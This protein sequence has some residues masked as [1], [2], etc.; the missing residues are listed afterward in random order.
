MDKILKLLEIA[1]KFGVKP[2]KVIGTQGNIV[3]YKKPSLVDISVDEFKLKESIDKGTLTMDKVQQEM[4]ETVKLALSKNLNDVELN[5]A[6]NNAINIDR[7]FFP[8]MA[9]VVE[10]G[11]KQQVTGKGLEEL[12]QKEG[13][14]AS[15]KTPLGQ[16]QLRG[17]RLEQEAKDLS[18]EFDIGTLIKGAGRDQLSEIRLHNEGLVRAVT[19]Q[20]LSEDIKAGKIKSLTLDDLGTSR[21]PIDYFRK[22][23]GENA[24]EQLDSLTA[25][26]NRLN[27]EQEAASLARS[28]FKFEPDETRTKGSMSYEELEKTIKGSEQPKETKVLDITTEGNKRKSIDEL[29]DEYNA[30]QDRLR[31]SD[32]EGGTAINYDEFNDLKKKN[33]DI[34]KVLEEKGI[35]SKI[36]EEIKEEGIVIP[37]RKKFP[38]PE[39]EGKAQGGIIG[40]AIG[41]RIGYA[42]GTSMAGLVFNP[43]PWEGPWTGPEILG[44]PRKGQYYNESGSS[45]TSLNVPRS[46]LYKMTTANIMPGTGGFP[47]GPLSSPTTT[48]D[49]IPVTLTERYKKYL[50]AAGSE[51]GDELYKS[52]RANLDKK[53]DG[54]RIGFA[55]GKSKAILDLIAKANKKLKGKKSMESVNPKTGEVTVPKEPIKTAEEPTGITVMDQEPNILD[56]KS[57]TTTKQQT[58]SRQLTN[59]EIADYEEQ[60]GRNAEEWLSE[61]TVDEAEKALKNSKAE[62]AYYLQQYKTGQLDP[63]PGEKSQSRMRFLQKK[64][65]EA[66]DVKDRRLFTLDEM[67]ELDELENMFRKK[68]EDRMKFLQKKFDE[69]LST[70]DRRFITLEEAQELQELQFASRRKPKVSEADMIKQKYGNVID[71]ELLQKIIVDD[72]PQRKA[73]VLASLD[74]ALKMEEKGIATEDIINIINNTTRTKQAKGGSAGG[75]DYLMGF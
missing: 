3:P 65:E 59:D 24:L 64:A 56:E 51:T 58:K 72:N 52:Y 66:E 11:S 43:G 36:E 35:S 15:P 31:L 71:E 21:E 18:K 48:N 23:Y 28:K 75:L 62:E 30:N 9:E 14:T 38:K 46:D 20:I 57:I 4:E 42:N 19:R 5:R 41:G 34:A 55:G 26:F 27:T 2:S 61:G 69:V 68:P 45:L 8:P 17:K 44:G 29:I 54:G 63:S 7:Q 73:E 1:K 12:I 53:A 50:S 40:Y 10:A 13:L 33:E 49:S 6:L 39:P 60:I 22:I 32:E 47:G 67:E 74:E 70:G 16:I 25:D 37:F